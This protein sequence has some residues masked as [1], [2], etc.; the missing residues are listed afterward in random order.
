MKA[1]VFIADEDLNVH[2]IY[3]YFCG[4]GL[5]P[6]TKFILYIYGYMLTSRRSHRLP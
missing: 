1:D 6:S 2:D 3:Y 4:T 5:D